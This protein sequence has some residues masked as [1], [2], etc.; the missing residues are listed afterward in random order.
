MRFA[1]DHADY[2]FSTAA[3]ADQF[4]MIREDLGGT[5]VGYIGRKHVIIR[6]TRA[7]AE[8]VAERIV[9]GGDKKAIAQLVAHGRGPVQAAE[10]RLSSEGALRA[11][12]LQEPI[13]GSPEEV[14][15]GLAE[16]A[17]SASVDGICLSLFEQQR[18]LDL[19]DD[20]F[21]ERLGNEL[22]ARGKSLV[23]T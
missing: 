10:E 14:A 20:R 5:E 11:F 19:M 13:L 9:A 15:V 6:E 21:M 12:L 8:D 1:I 23:M 16:W 7:E 18:S 4:R 22:D 3:D 17:A 2:L